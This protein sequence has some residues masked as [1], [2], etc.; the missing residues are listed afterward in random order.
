MLTKK[1]NLSTKCQYKNLLKPSYEV[2][3]SPSLTIQTVFYFIHSQGLLVCC[4][5]YV[6]T[7]GS[8]AASRTLHHQ[9]LDS[10][11]HLPL[12]HFETNPVGQIINR[13]TKV[14]G[15]LS[16]FSFKKMKLE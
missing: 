11:L 5:A 13:F 6:L 1:Q 12:Q 3:S 2:K 14:N 16:I 15:K 7:Q 4:G 9:L 8:L 10:V